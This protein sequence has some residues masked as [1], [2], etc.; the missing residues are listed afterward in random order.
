VSASAGRIGL[1][2]APRVRT[3]LTVVVLDG[4]AVIYDEESGDVHHLNPTATLVFQMLDGAV[5]VAELADDV[6]A[7]FE[8]EPAEATAQVQ[9]LVDELADAGLIDGMPA[10]P[11]EHEVSVV[12]P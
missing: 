6:A 3:D 10:A 5:T 1:G 2:A 7:V 8:L 4:E 11:R 12:E 9:A